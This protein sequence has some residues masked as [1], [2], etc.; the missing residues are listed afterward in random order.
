M[1]TP[2]YAALIDERRRGLAADLAAIFP[3]G[4]GEFLCE[5]GCGHGHFLTAYA[6]EHPDVTCLGLDLVGDRIE[7]AVRKRDRANLG[8]LHFIQAEARLFLEVLPPEVR[9]CAYVL[10]FPDP[11]PKLRHHKHRLMQADFLNQAAGRAAPGCRLYFRTDYD[12]Y[13]EDAATAV[14]AHPE[15]ERVGDPWIFEHETVFQQRA[16]S[17]QSLVA[18]LREKPRN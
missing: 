6:A 13:F 16:P 3:A 4:K 11:W 12:P 7:R 9:I 17:H 2:R 18:R 14:S 5:I 10:L 1:I 15:W 8:R